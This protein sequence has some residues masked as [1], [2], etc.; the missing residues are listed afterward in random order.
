MGEERERVCIDQRCQV[1]KEKM[2][3]G[4]RQG[5]LQAASREVG[6]LRPEQRHPS[7]PATSSAAGKQ[8]YSLSHDFALQAV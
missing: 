6:C 2:V 4:E 8:A 1:K 5:M 3:V 7:K